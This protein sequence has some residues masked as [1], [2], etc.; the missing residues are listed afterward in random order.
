MVDFSGWYD[1]IDDQT[2][3]CGFP[4][5]APHVKDLFNTYVEEGFIPGRAAFIA[6][7]TWNCEPRT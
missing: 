6:L 1:Y 4:G 5:I 7:E 2:K 3:S